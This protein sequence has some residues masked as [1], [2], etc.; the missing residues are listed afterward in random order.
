[1]L[2]RSGATKTASAR[3][4]LQNNDYVVWT[5]GPIVTTVLLSNDAQS[6]TCGGKAASKY[7][8]GFDSFCAFRPR[9]EAQFWAGTNQVF[10]RYIGEITNTEQ[11]EDVVADKVVL[12]TGSVNLVT[13]YTLPTAKSP[14]TMFGGSRWTK[15]FWINGTPSPISINHNL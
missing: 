1:A 13:V 8:F 10:V 7:D 9:F 12:S 6:T 15:A 3:A 2:T 14:L 4:M 5:S 11:L